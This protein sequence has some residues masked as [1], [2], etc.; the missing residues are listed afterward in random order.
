MTQIQTDGQLYA[1]GPW[2]KTLYFLEHE[3]TATTP[4]QVR[5]KLRTYKKAL[6]LGIRFRAIWITET[7]GAATQ[8]LNPNPPKG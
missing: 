5:V 3:R 1:N 6:G 7:R 2:G 8:F 4:E